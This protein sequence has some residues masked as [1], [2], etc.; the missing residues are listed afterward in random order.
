MKRSW[1]LLAA[2]FGVAGTVQTLGQVVAGRTIAAPTATNAMFYVQMQDYLWKEFDADGSK[3]LEESGF[4]YA[5]VLEGESWRN[6]VGMGGKIQV[7]WGGV[8]YDGSTMSGTSV[9]SQT[10]Y[11]GADI[12]GNVR[13]RIDLGEAACLKPFVGV[14]VRMWRREIGDTA[15]ACGY[16]ETWTVFDGRAGLQ[17]EW[18]FAESSRLYAKGGCR[19][20]LA[21]REEVDWSEFGMSTVS[22]EPKQQITPFAEIGV[23]W[24][25]FMLGGFYESLEFDKS[26]S[27]TETYV[28]WPY[29]YTLEFY[30]PES[31]AEI[32]GVSLGFACSF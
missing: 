23:Q 9:V 21:A 30:Q 29:M 31:T 28:S 22:L 19:L 4:L 16:P 6:H 13:G 8:D 18:Y 15:T 14:G 20:P 25:N 27:V 1:A 24:K 5:I 12:E 7:F 3:L 2:V 17:A 11:F 10:D 26:D 32:W